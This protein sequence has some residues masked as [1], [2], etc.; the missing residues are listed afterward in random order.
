MKLTRREGF[1]FS[2]QRLISEQ[3]KKQLWKTQ[4]QQLD[5]GNSTISERFR[6]T[7]KS[8]V[9]DWDIDTLAG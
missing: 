6:S 3:I 8:E 1:F 5:D 2:T 7:C 4:L 9:P